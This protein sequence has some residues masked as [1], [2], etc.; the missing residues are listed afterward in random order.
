MSSKDKPRGA[1]PVGAGTPLNPVQVAF[2]GTCR[3]MVERLILFKSR[4]DAFVSDYDNQQ[5]ALPTDAVALNDLD[6]SNPR[7]D[8]PILTGAD[9]LSLRNFCANMSAQVN[10][11][12]LAALIKVAVRDLETIL[13]NPM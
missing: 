7:T 11:A 10:A 8:A 5:V 4:M 2:V 12:A 13:R 3:T 9:V 6:G 1:N